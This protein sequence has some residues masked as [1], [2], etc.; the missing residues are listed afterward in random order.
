[1]YCG[2]VRNPRTSSEVSDAT[3]D[4]QQ[5]AAFRAETKTLTP[6]WCFFAEYDDQ[7]FRELC[8]KVNAVTGEVILDM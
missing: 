6:M 8:I 4:S 3:L 1:M 2:I 5:Q 7:E